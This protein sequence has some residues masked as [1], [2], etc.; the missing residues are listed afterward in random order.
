MQKI[1]LIAALAEMDLPSISHVGWL[2]SQIELRPA[3]SSLV[4]ASN[5][6]RLNSKPARMELCL[7][8]KF[9]NIDY[10]SQMTYDKRTT[11]GYENFPVEID[12]VRRLAT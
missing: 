12:V 6:A 11:Q 9:L 7:I 10:K 1:A 8:L 3:E 2:L 4:S 5:R